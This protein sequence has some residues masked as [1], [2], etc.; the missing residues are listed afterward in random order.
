MPLK[1]LQPDEYSEK[2]IEK[3]TASDFQQKFKL[4]SDKS[5]HAGEPVVPHHAAYHAAHQTTP[6]IEKLSMLLVA[7]VALIILF[8]QLQIMQV[9]S[10][11]A[12]GVSGTGGIIS[13]GPTADKT[14][15]NIKLDASADVVNEVI[16]KLIPTGTPQDYG[17]ELGVSFDDPVASL[18]VIAK[19]H[20]AVPTNTLTAE[21]KERYVSVASHISCEFCCSAPAV[22]RPDGSDACGCSHALAIMGLTKYLVT[23][24]GDTWTDDQIYWEVT[25]W[26][27][28][29]FP[30]NMVEKGVALANAGLELDAVSLNDAAL[31]KK[32]QAGGDVGGD[33]SSLPNMVG[34]C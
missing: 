16:K 5:H 33:L 17:P 6:P 24:H 28:L 4:P 22:V 26:K 12:N 9:S 8:N 10:M 27:S 30:K 19:L 1:V 15:G 18:S 2:P 34:G 31:L 11:I 7:I 20:R 3:P 14:S 23:E 13:S 29:F 21:Q 25:R 32:L